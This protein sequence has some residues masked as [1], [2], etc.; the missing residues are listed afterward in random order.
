MGWTKGGEC[1]GIKKWQL[2][3]RPF[4]RA[5]PLQ[6]GPSA[7]EQGVQCSTLVQ[8]WLLRPGVGGGGLVRVQSHRRSSDGAFPVVRL[9]PQHFPP[10]HSISLDPHLN[11]RHFSK[12]GFCYFDQLVLNRPIFWIL[13][14]M[15]LWSIARSKI[16]DNSILIGAINGTLQPS[17]NYT[18]FWKLEISRHNNSCFHV[19][20]VAWIHILAKKSGH[21][22]TSTCPRNCN[23]LLFPASSKRPVAIWTWTL[24]S[25]AA[26]SGLPNLFQQFIA[27][28]LRYNG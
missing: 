26:R 4:P 25:Q 13:Q 15:I 23:W 5:P 16:L 17:N 9:S 20:H 14:F 28:S 3:C 19:V 8:G 27:S 7:D 22:A 18:K 1:V 6:E 10:P 24:R 12:L 21:F 11:T 2:G